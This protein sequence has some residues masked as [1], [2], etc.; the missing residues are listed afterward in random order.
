MP[1]L[2]N[3]VPQRGTKPR[4]TDEHLIHAPETYRMPWSTL[5]AAFINQ[6][7]APAGT[8][9]P[10]RAGSM[11]G[12]TEFLY[13]RD[14]SQWRRVPYDTGSW[15]DNYVRLLRPV[16]PSL[17]EAPVGAPNGHFYYDSALQKLRFKQ[18]G[19]YATLPSAYSFQTLTDGS[20]PVNAG[21]SGLFKFRSSNSTIL[22]TTTVGDPTHGDN[23]N[24]RVNVGTIN[25]G[26]FV[27]D[28]TYALAAHDHDGVY[29][30][31]G[32][33]HTG[34]YAPLVHNHDGVY[35][36]VAHDHTGV[37]APVSHNQ[38]ASTITTGTFADGRVAASNVT[39]HQAALNHNAL[40]NYVANQHV[41]H[42]TVTIG[43]GTGLTGGGDLTTSRTISLNIPA[44]TALV[45]LDTTNDMLLVYD[46]DAATY[47][48]LPPSLLLTGFAAASHQHSAAEIA[49]GTLSATRGGLGAD[50][51]AFTG[52]IKMSGGVASVA[53]AGVD[54]ASGSHTHSAGSITTGVLAAVN[55]GLGAD[56][57]AFTG[58]I[59]MAGGVASAATA[60]VD[61]AAVAH[62][63]AAS[64][65]TDFAA[66]VTAHVD[67]AANSAAR[68]T[69][70]TDTGTTSSYFQI[71]SDASGGRVYFTA[72]E[73]QLKN[74]DNS[75]Y[76]DLRVRNLVVTGATTTVESNEVNI[77]DAEI[78]LN[79]DLTDGAVNSNG[80][81]AVKLLDDTDDITRRDAKMV[82]DLSARRWMQTGFTATTAAPLTKTSAAVHS[83]LIGDGSNTSY[84]ITHNLNSTA[85]VVS[86]VNASTGAAVLVDWTVTSANAVQVVFG[87]S[88]VPSTNSR[89]VTIVG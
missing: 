62:T 3:S 53:T 27:D 86:V 15:A 1:L 75:A 74:Y 54:Y 6:E 22:V 2:Y 83:E 16:A 63:H 88:S 65:I 76:A 60:G 50:A 30:A 61:Y 79:S 70:G 12:D 5:R 59:K 87:A 14:S 81:I 40:T 43:T 71:D 66:A 85:V 44:L 45:S 55:G 33:T 82:Y 42:S 67:V 7:T 20:T 24:L 25:V 89:R 48:K 52:M 39:Q 38:D 10:G 64:A 72:G 51:S 58:L 35:S 34:T 80:G 47:K 77:G 68:H 21:E 37:Y 4:D 69:Q 17:A 29:S 8:T 56:A 32:H 84:T 9:A 18:G 11:A 57:S 31:V 49:S 26:S 19:T 13:F 23:L 73:F 41:D 46:A 78:L 36:P 28:G